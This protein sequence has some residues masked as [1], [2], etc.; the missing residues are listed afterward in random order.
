MRAVGSRLQVF[1]GKAKKTSGG[2]KKS[3]LKKNSVGKIVSKKKS[4]LAK[5]SSNL[6][7]HLV[8]RNKKKPKKK[9]KKKPKK[10]PDDDEELLDLT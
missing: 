9:L 8:K 3:Q 10:K 2:L 5:K 4:V 1:K 6:K 7:A